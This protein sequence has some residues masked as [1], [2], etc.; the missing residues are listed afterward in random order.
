MFSDEEFFYLKQ[1][2]VSDFKKRFG[3]VDKTEKDVYRL[4]MCLIN[5]NKK[6]AAFS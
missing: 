6:E 2:G 4:R 3:L 1:H 5:K